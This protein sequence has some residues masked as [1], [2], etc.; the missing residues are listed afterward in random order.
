MTSVGINGFGR[1][2]KCVFIQLL[3]NN[4]FKVRAINAPNF[5]IKYID[6]YLNYDSVHKYDKMD[7]EIIDSNNFKIKNNIVHIFNTRNAVEI[8]WK[9]YDV[10]H[11][12][13]ATGSY[14]TTEKCK[15]H[16]AEYVIM[17]APPKDNTP[18]YVP[19]VNC[20]KYS[21]EKIVSNASCT[22]NSITPLLKFS[23]IEYSISCSYRNMRQHMA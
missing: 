14:L 11:V 9:K 17:C 19:N 22:T 18:L 1:I 6:T 21:G 13:D 12:I 20:Y 15:E 5:D 2:G 3:K 8:D 16:N 4:K 10:N 7:I 23:S